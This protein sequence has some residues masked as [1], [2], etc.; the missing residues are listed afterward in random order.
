MDRKPNFLK[1]SEYPTGLELDI[2]YYEYGFAIEV[3]GEQHEKYIEFFHRRDPNNFIKQQER[4]QTQERIMRRELSTPPTYYLY[5]QYSTPSR[6]LLLESTKRLSHS[7]SF[8]PIFVL[9]KIARRFD[10]RCTAKPQ[11]RYYV[12]KTRFGN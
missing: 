8:V 9:G 5:A 2:P 10:I 3:Q 1:T 12:D 11:K 7:V 4:D 6:K